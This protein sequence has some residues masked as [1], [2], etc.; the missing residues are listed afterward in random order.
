MMGSPGTRLRR[1]LRRAGSLLQRAGGSPNGS[2]LDVPVLQPWGAVDGLEVE[3]CGIVRVR[4]WHRDSGPVHPP[5]TLEA[6]GQVMPLLHTFRVFRPDVAKHLN[7]PDDYLGFICEY[8]LTPE[9]AASPSLRVLAGGEMIAQARA[10]NRYVQPAYA[11]L[12]S[13]ARIR[14]RDD[15]YGFG[16]PA[17]EL[18]DPEVIAA[19]KCVTG[20][21]LDLGCGLGLAVR[22]LR[23]RGIEAQGIEIN[24]PAIADALQ[25]DIRPYIQLYDGRLPLPFADDAFSTVVCLEVLEHIPDPEQVISEIARVGRDRVVLSVPDM[26]AIP[27]CFPNAV[28]PWHLLESTHVN[29]FTQQSL[30][31]LLQKH[32]PKVT[33]GRL[34]PNCINDCTYYTNLLA[35]AEKVSGD[36]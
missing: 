4:G 5:L 12:I 30:T 16:L 28:V 24:R 22:H 14:H 3:P 1:W 13:D 9:H 7:S 15:I 2:L 19:L 10:S 27:I 6:N 17:R 25:E 35:I 32:Y 11:G 18:N 26:S 23:G 8:Q 20:P 21:A 31:R 33:I 34:H 36:N 29:F